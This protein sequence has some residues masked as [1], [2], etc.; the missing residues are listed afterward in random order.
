[1]N[2]TTAAVDDEGR[3]SKAMAHAEAASLL[4]DED[5]SP[6]GRTRA[7]GGRAA[8]MCAAAFV[9]VLVLLLVAAAQMPPAVQAT[10]AMAGHRALGGGLSGAVA[11]VAQ[12]LTLMWLRTAMNYQYRF[13]G[14][15]EDSLRTLYS[16]GGVSRFYQGVGWALLQNPLSRFG[17]TAANTGVLAIFEATAFGASVPIGARTAVASGAAALWRVL[18]TPLDTCKTTLQVEGRGAY[19]LLLRRAENDGWLTL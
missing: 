1:M 19:A 16:Q 3:D 10:L 12:V 13:A 18:I 17:D 6:K 7:S 11:G 5:R 2:Q 15:L 14:S 9:L 8:T 4:P